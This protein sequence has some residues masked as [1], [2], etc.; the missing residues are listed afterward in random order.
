[1]ERRVKIEQVEI[2]PIVIK[3]DHVIRYEPRPKP[4]LLSITIVNDEGRKFQLPVINLAGQWFMTGSIPVS[5]IT[6]DPAHSHMQFK[7]E[8]RLEY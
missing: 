7:L 2:K 6:D 8:M 4:Q 3:H 5:F 1:M